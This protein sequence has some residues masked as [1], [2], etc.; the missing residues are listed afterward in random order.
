MISIITVCRNAEDSIEKTI[1]SVLGQTDK[2]F[3]Y[4]IIDG[5][6]TD[7]TLEI[8][9]KYEKT[10]NDQL[11]RFNFLSEPDKG[12][13]NAMNKGINM[14][15]AEWLLFL[16][17]GDSLYDEKVIEEAN[18]MLGV[19]EEDVMFSCGDVIV[20]SEKHS[21]EY[22]ARDV[23]EIN[24][25]M[26]FCHQA[27]FNRRKAISEL[28]YN[29]E[30]KVSADYDLYMRAYVNK[31]KFEKN[32]LLVAEY[33]ADG[34]SRNNAYLMAKEMLRIKT[35][36]GVGFLRYFDYFVLCLKIWGKDILGR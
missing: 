6:S 27:I 1:R 22:K 20:S 13:Y 26:P 33:M 30:Y 24:R 29:E 2:E 12:I 17:S 21:F 28:K 31:F 4:I 19:T 9:N 8:I 25:L 18:K 36:N 32:N 5:A 16:N 3:E 10:L 34:F 23:E 35:T 11:G 14:A 7:K 15:T